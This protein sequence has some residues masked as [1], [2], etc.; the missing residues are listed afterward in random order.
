MPWTGMSTF[1]PAFFSVVGIAMRSPSP[2]H[3]EL[4]VQHAHSAGNVERPRLPGRQL[5]RRLLE[6]GEELADA[7][8][9]DHDLLR[10]TGI[11]LAIEDQAYGLA[12]LHLHLGGLVAPMDRDG[13]LLRAP[14]ASGRGDRRALGQEEV[15]VDPGDRRDPREDDRPIRG[16]H[17]SLSV[18]STG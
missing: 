5:D 17:A 9:G 2:L 11:L 8:L 3:D 6:G 12:L 18:L 4:A 14:R 1:A 13:D 10:A 7:E 16:A 15:P